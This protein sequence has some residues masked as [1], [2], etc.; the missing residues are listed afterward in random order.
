MCYISL[1]NY[2]VRLTR[3][4]YRIDFHNSHFRLFDELRVAYSQDS[5]NLKGKMR[6]A[7]QEKQTLAE[8]LTDTSTY[9][10]N[11]T[12]QVSGLKGSLR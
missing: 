8:K 11:L 5:G 9:V 7:R 10:H 6:A 12:G 4:G 2:F 3:K 1:I